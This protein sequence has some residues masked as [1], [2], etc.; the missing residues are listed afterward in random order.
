MTTEKLKKGNKYWFFSET[1][2]PV[3]GFETIYHIECGEFIGKEDGF[4]SFEV[5]DGNTHIFLEAEWKDVY[6]T[7]EELLIGKADDFGREIGELVERMRSV[8]YNRRRFCELAKE[9]LASNKEAK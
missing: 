3:G 9:K 6:N 5:V 7:L 8:E 1:Y 4:P 2:P